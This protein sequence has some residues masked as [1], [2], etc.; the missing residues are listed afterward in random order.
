MERTK[1]TS[2]GVTWILTF[3]TFALTSETDA[4]S[5]CQMCMF[6]DT[7]YDVMKPW[8]MLGK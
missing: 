7:L 1:M 6:P 3:V 8:K 5:K 2:Q 4:C